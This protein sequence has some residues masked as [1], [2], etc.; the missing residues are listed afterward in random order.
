MR[1]YIVGGFSSIAFSAFHSLYADGVEVECVPSDTQG[2]ISGQLIYNPVVKVSKLVLREGIT[3]IGDDAFPWCD[4]PVVLPSTITDIGSRVTSGRA[5]VDCPNYAFY[6]KA[7]VPPT[8]S[9]SWLPK[10]IPLHIPKG[11]L[12]VYS[13]ATGWSAQASRLV[14]YDFDADIDNINQYC[15]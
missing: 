7:T 3:R 11:T 9:N 2:V 15:V 1:K 5:P 10:S 14:E 12:N 6:I 8:L 13:S 4:C